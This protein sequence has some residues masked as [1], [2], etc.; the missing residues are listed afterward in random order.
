MKSFSLNHFDARYVTGKNT[1]SRGSAIASVSALPTNSKAI[2]YQN[3][4]IVCDALAIDEI[5]MPYKQIIP[6]SAVRGAIVRKAIDAK[7]H[8]DL[9]R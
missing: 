2:G 5:R 1:V 4:C 6:L 3:T 9:A 8:S 7:K